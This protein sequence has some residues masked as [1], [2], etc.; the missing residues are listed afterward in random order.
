MNAGILE[1]INILKTFCPNIAKYLTQKGDSIKLDNDKTYLDMART[2]YLECINYP[3]YEYILENAVIQIL[4]SYLA[5]RS[6]WNKQYDRLQGFGD[7]LIHIDSEYK[8]NDYLV[9][10]LLGVMDTIKSSRTTQKYNQIKERIFSGTFI[11]GNWKLA[12]N[13][14]D[15]LRKFYNKLPDSCESAEELAESFEIVL[16][17]YQ[18]Y[19]NDF[20]HNVNEFKNNFNFTINGIIAA[21][22]LVKE[23]D[24]FY[25]YMLETDKKRYD[26]FLSIIDEVKS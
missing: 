23:W 7:K 14:Y 12:S 15:S 20:I 24:S 13:V 19:K 2:Y 17:Q 21:G 9:C 4:L 1:S 5:T 10:A 26:Q 11:P 3:C 18:V 6:N 8:E 22:G 16:E 25:K